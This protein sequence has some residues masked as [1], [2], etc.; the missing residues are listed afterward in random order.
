MTTNK[1]KKLFAATKKSLRG[2]LSG[3]QPNPIDVHIGK[4]IL[5]R[6]TLLKMSQQELA[7]RLGITFQ[8]VQKYETGRNRVSGSRLWD[9]SKELEVSVDY[10]FDDMDSADA[11]QSPR[12]L[13][14]PKQKEEKIVDPMRSEEI[15][16]LV[17]AYYRI[18]NRK[19]AKKIYK[20]A[21]SM[22]KNYTDEQTM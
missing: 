13:Y 4:R 17:R 21:I 9:L 16:T 19:I 3:G 20:L 12:M 6:R 15:I 7:K 8:Q 11:Q 5:L 10:F 1:N 18:P 14:V 2:R 22:S